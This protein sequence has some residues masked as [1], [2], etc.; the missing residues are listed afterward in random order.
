MDPSYLVRQIHR[1]VEPFGLRRVTIPGA[2][3]SAFARADLWTR[4]QTL[5][6]VETTLEGEPAQP[7]ILDT[8]PEPYSRTVPPWLRGL[9]VLGGVAGLLIVSALVQSGDPPPPVT[10]PVLLG[11]PATEATAVLDEAGLRA[12]TMPVPAC[13]VGRRTLRS[14]PP[15]GAEVAVGS[16]VRV[17]YAVASDDSC[18]TR[19]ADRESAWQ[20][21]DFALGR[22]RP[23]AF[24]DEVFVQVP[25][26][27][28]RA[29]TAAE[30]VDPSSWG[31][32]SP[33]TM[34]ASAARRPQATLNLPAA[35]SCSSP[36]ALESETTL[37]F[38]IGSPDTPGCPDV[39]MASRDR[40][41]RIEALRVSAS[42][43]LDGLPP[44]VKRFFDSLDGP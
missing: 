20:L 30:A 28:P 43:E 33:L 6:R 42:S 4:L 41:G 7:E 39:V 29:L 10:V 2:G 22:G 14:H 8:G 40:A 18:R 19:L 15:N 12:T 23:P 11:L 13:E 38:S 37:S 24:A 25:G 35:R 44:G 31:A 17:E 5:A 9:V 3:D 26:L 27:A 34:M 32:I 21:I 36:P 1:V 16:T